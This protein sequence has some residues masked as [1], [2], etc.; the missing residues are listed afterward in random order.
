MEKQDVDVD[1]CHKNTYCKPNFKVLEALLEG[2]DL[3][4]NAAPVAKYVIKVFENVRNLH[5][6]WSLQQ[7]LQNF[8]VSFWSQ[9][10]NTYIFVTVQ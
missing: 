7:S 4:V 3:D 5:Q 1:V 6:L 9:A 10:Y 8:E 2:Q